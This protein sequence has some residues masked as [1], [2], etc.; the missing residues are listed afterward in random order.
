M[1]CPELGWIG[2]REIAEY[3]GPLG[4]GI[5]RD[6]HFTAKYPLSV[7]A[8]AARAAQHIVE[9]GPHLDAAATHIATPT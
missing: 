9:Y 3:T 6:L 8:D 1:G 4:I 5:E 7:Y 2:L